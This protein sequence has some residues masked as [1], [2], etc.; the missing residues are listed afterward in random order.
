MPEEFGGSGGGF[1]GNTIIIE[2][3]SRVCMGIGLNIVAATFGCEN[4]HY[5]GTKEQKENTYLRFVQ[6]TRSL[7]EHIRSRTRAR[8]WQ[9]TRQ[10]LFRMAM[11]I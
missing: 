9:V 4:I 8:M 11:T 6:E 5:Y 1:L 7:P 3:L 10:G 2:Q